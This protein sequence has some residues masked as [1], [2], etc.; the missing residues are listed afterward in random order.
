MRRRK[1]I[2]SSLGLVCLGAFF[3]W[4][5]TEY[6]RCEAQNAS[7]NQNLNDLLIYPVKA[8]VKKTT[9]PDHHLNLV[10]K[11]KTKSADNYPDMWPTQGTITSLFGLRFHPVLH[12]YRFH[13]GV[14]IANFKN[15][16]VLAAADAV[17]MFA[18]HEKGYGNLVILDHGNGF[19]TVYGHAEDILVSAGEEVK[20]GQLI[21]GMGSTGV[22]TGDHLHFE[23]RFAGEAVDPTVFI[24]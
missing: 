21:A 20:K 13:A 10:S 9:H 16:E 2:I 22:S 11:S 14:D 12:R 24:K 17:V 8:S 1:W 23:I 4:H 15:T 19:E 18:G 7:Y 6:Q 3:A 5:Q